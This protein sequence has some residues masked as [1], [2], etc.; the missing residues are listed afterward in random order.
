MGVDLARESSRA[1]EILE[2]ADA[3]LG[4]ALSRIMAG[5][6]GEELHR[7]V[8]TQPAV[9]VHSM[10]LYEVLRERFPVNVVVAAGHSVGEYSAL[11]AAGVFDFEDALDVI[12]VRAKWMDE[13]QP[14]GTCGMAAIIGLDRYRVLEFVSAHRGD[15]ELAAANFNAPDQVVISGE[16]EAVRRAIRAV[17]VERKARAVMLPVSSA[18]HTALMEPARVPLA[19][20][21]ATVSLSP[22]RFPVVANV[23]AQVYSDS[24]E[25]IRELL[26]NQVVSPVLWEDC[27]RTMTE[28]GAACFLEVG[29]G[30]VLSGILRRIDRSLRCIS[31]SDLDAI[32]SLEVAAT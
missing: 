7:T 22:A 17:G 4:Y 20:R 12:R 13:A 26:V 15:G 9:F 23:N 16:L 18:F 28:R 27:V 1:R 6:E 11:C 30:K 14:A 21:L 25:E 29:P 2:R 3:V 24:H 10:T 31:V 32:R 19:H 8:H 5:D